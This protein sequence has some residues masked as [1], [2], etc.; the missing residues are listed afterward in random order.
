MP[1]T[2]RGTR[3]SRA[4]PSNEETGP[5]LLPEL[6]RRVLGLG[7]S[8][9][10]MT[11]EALRRALGD[12]L[13]KDWIDFAVEQ[14]ERTRAEFL[15]R[16]AGEMARTL[17]NVDVLTVAERLLAGHRI[18]V[19]AQIRLVADKGKSTARTFRFDLAQGG[20]RR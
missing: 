5:G 18:E 10:F 16:F 13:P 8:G 17:E 15:E 2:R 1:T 7:F 6:L 14:S 4:E 19:K 9:F 12:T 11:E 3:R 20:G